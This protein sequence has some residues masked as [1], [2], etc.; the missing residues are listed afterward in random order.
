MLQ[1]PF[2]VEELLF[3]VDLSGS[4]PTIL[5]EDK[6]MEVPHYKYE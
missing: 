6:L 4:C 3:L 5:G 2:L 1:T